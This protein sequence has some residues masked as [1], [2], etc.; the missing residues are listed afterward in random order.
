MKQCSTKINPKYEWT[1]NLTSEGS[2]NPTK[3][4]FL[5]PLLT[6]SIRLLLSHSASLFLSLSCSPTLYFSRILLLHQ[7]DLCSSALSF[8]YHRSSCPPSII[9]NTQYTV[10]FIAVWLC[11]V[12]TLGL[13]HSCCLSV[14]TYHPLTIFNFKLNLLPIIRYLLWALPWEKICIKHSA[15]SK[16]ILYLWTPYDT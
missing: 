9:W 11:K 13:D 3:L 1:N 12:E 8:L 7:A 14:S 15:Q 2:L 5:C 6:D 16:R 10:Q 4:L